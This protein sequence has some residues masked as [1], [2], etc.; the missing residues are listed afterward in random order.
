MTLFSLQIKDLVAVCKIKPSMNQV[1]STP[2]L[3]QEKLMEVCKEHGIVL[4]A[5]S[6]F[7]GSPRANPENEGK[8]DDTPHKKA[9]WD[10]EVLKKLA[11]KYGKKVSQILLKFHVQ[12]GVVT[13]P[14]SV[15]KERIIENANIFDFELT[16]DELASLTILKNGERLVFLE[17]MKN[18]KEF[19]FNEE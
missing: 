10:N 11:D 4:T 14:K 9:L 13:I 5:Y 19:P 12:R 1:E 17:I 18:C 6:P 3:P 2:F 16:D 7:G 8:E 15:T